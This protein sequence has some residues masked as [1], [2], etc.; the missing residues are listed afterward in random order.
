MTRAQ[1]ARKRRGA[2]RRCAAAAKCACPHA[3]RPIS[4]IDLVL[5][6][7]GAGKLPPTPAEQS[8]K[9]IA[10]K[11]LLLGCFEG[12]SVLFRR[13]SRFLIFRLTLSSRDRRYSRP[14][15]RSTSPAAAD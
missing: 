11:S 6:V 13:A 4:A 7:E 14:T 9:H 5:K 15:A 12:G 2:A 3:S 10:C 8:D 1:A